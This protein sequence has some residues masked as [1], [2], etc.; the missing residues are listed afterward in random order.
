M[1]LISVQFEYLTGLRRQFIV[2]A[3]LGGSWD[4]SGHRADA[5]SFTA[6]TPFT[7]DDG[8]PA[9]R[10]TVQLDDSQIGQAFRW[11]VS[12][13]TQ[14]LAPV[15]GIPT[16]LNDRASSERYRVFTLHGADQTERYYLTQCRRLGANKFYVDGQSRPGIRFAVWAPNA[17]TVELVRGL[18]GGPRPQG[19]ADCYFLELLEGGYVFNDGRPEAI[20]ATFPMHHEDGG[21]WATNVA[22]ASEL[23]NFA[24][25]DHTP[26]MFRITR[27]DGSIVYRTDLYSRCQIGKGDVN[28]ETDRSWSGRC[29]DV[30]GSKSCSV[31]VDPERVTELFSEEVAEEVVNDQRVRLVWP[32]TR[33]L[34][35]HDVPEDAFWSDEFRPDHPLPA[36]LEDLVIYELHVG[37]LGLDR[38]VGEGTLE[39]AI[40][41]LHRN[42]LVNL[43]DGEGTRAAALLLPDLN[44]LLDLGVNAIELMPMSEFQ[45]RL[46]YGYSTSHYMAVEYSGGGRDQFKHFV[47]ACHQ[48]GIAVLLDVVY[49]H[50]TFDAE[51]AEWNYDSN[52]PE[53]NIYYW[54]EGRATDYARPDGGYLDNGSSGFAPRLWEEMVRKM[55]ISS[56]AALV[57]EF[58]FDGFRVDLTTA[59]HR[60]NVRHSDGAS[61]GAANVFGQKFLREWTRT[62]RLINPNAF[63]IAED[64][65]G[66]AAV[67]Q[68]ADQG[69]LGFDATWFAEYYH[70]LIGD[71]QNDPSRARLLKMAGY[72]D[73]RSLNITA[74][75]GSLANTASGGKVVYH[76]LH[77][78]AGNSSY[79][80]GGQRVHSARTI[81]VAVNGAPLVGETRQYAETRVHFAASVTLLA[82]AIPMFFMGEEV[83]ASLPYLFDSF[84]NAREGFHVL[85]QGAGATLFHF[86]Q[87]LI[88]LRLGHPGLHS[89]KID[90]LHVHDANRMLVFRRWEGP[91]DLIVVASLSNFPFANGYRVQNARIPDG[92]WVEV[93]N[94]DAARY[95][96]G[97]LANPDLTSAGGVFTPVVPAN[98]VLVFQRQ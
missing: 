7:A 77:D 78:E 23:Q 53:R 56:A 80:E 74:F 40:R 46:G 65:S 39:D 55:F 81:A 20:A 97:G 33:W 79:E 28:P 66:W 61:V 48:R 11:G 15:W 64:H 45:N 34:P 71:A 17:L 60:D 59:L 8:C 76:E 54:Y 12:V 63:L 94:S 82:P 35:P 1:P 52:A 73:N 42:Y 93:L 25:F 70:H 9:F 95:G 85:R 14:S 4:G 87:D 51:R 47:K 67:T 62:L 32:E 24:L 16:E 10:A 43:G 21:I 37:G 92:E 91:E 84:A 6:M 75:A 26:Y 86:Y 5:W 31:V 50:Y 89:H 2:N 22:D 88:R 98:S 57:S 3:R 38:G 13:D 36:R 90:I 96:G 49:N 83:G 29:L 44:Y 19:R 72:G 58:H 68:S 30:D 18:V 41:L 69:G 27:D